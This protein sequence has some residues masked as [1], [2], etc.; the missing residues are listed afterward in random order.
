MARE[1]HDIV[2]HQVSAI[3][4]RVGMARH[5]PELGPDRTAQLLGDIHGTAD[6]A[7]RDLHD[8]MRVRI[9]SDITATGMKSAGGF[10]LAGMRER[11]ATVGG[12]L[13]YGPVGTGWQLSASIDRRAAS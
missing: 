6:A 4:V 9:D 11:L 5:L 1:L 3:L 7:L 8:L 13:H 12:D 2:A 10:G